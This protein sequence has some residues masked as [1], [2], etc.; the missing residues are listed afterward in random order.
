MDL[1]KH[2][3]LTLLLLSL[4]SFSSC[5]IV[6]FPS[7]E[8]IAKLNMAGITPVFGGAGV[9][10]GRALGEKDKLPEMY[11]ILEKGGCKNIDTAA[12]CKKADGWRHS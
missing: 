10:A 6:A 5:Y 3:K 11:A 8:S 2:S 7:Y 4:L 9:A 1:E 12:L